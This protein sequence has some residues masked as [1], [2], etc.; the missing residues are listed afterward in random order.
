MQSIQ[1]CPYTLCCTI[2][3]SSSSLP[4]QER[5]GNLTNKCMDG[6]AADLQYFVQEGAHILGLQEQAHNAKVITLCLS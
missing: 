1:L 2:A 3:L 4:V 5:L 6:G